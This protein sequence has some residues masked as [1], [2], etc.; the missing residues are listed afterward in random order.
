M[1]T[2]AGSKPPVSINFPL[3][4]AANVANIHNV[5]IPLNS[6]YINGFATGLTSGDIFVVLQ[7]NGNDIGILNMSYTVAKSLGD[8]LGQLISS[9][10]RRSD[11]KIMTSNES[12]E[13]L[14][15][16]DEDIKKLA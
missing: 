14:S 2:P 10:E 6:I 13:A 9:L 4:N 7:R 16:K 3:P 11:R 5:Q 1:E 15:K 8:A 12:A